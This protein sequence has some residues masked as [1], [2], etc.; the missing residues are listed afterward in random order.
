[1]TTLKYV[2]NKVIVASLRGTGCRLSIREV[3]TLVEAL[4]Q[5]VIDDAPRPLESAK[6]YRRV[7]AQKEQQG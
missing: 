4:P 7:G 1:M 3:Q 2:L 6:D 5:E